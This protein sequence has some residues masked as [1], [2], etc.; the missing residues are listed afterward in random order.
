[1]CLYQWNSTQGSLKDNIIRTNSMRNACKLYTLIA[2]LVKK[3]Q[4]K[5]KSRLIT[6]GTVSILVRARH[7]HTTLFKQQQKQQL[8]LLIN[9][10][11]CDLKNWS[12]RFLFID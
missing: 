9:I 4:R 8:H 12:K 3:P 2:A 6:I 1:M 5:K 11:K 10:S 7:N